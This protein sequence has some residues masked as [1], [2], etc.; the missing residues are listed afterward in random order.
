MTDRVGNIPVCALGGEMVTAAHLNVL[1]A[2]ARGENPQ[3]YPMMRDKLRHELG[4]I[5]PAAPPRPIQPKPGHQ[6]APRPRRHVLTPLGLTVLVEL[7]V[8]P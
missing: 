7:G 5:I 1:A 8:A 4:L 2:I 6:P 3:M